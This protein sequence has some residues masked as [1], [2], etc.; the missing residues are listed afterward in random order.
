[1]STLKTTSTLII[2][3]L[4]PIK[5]NPVQGPIALLTFGNV[6]IQLE[7]QIMFSLF[8]MLPDKKEFNRTVELLAAGFKEISREMQ[9]AHTSKIPNEHRDSDNKMLLGM[10]NLLNPE[11]FITGDHLL[12]SKETAAKSFVNNHIKP[13][14]EL[15]KLITQVEKKFINCDKDI[16]ELS[17]LIKEEGLIDILVDE[18]FVTTW[19]YE[20]EPEVAFFEFCKIYW[21]G[22]NRNGVLA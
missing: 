13:D 17:Y 15:E 22:Y 19:A 11:S 6:T 9:F 20:D 5:T 12:L 2:N 14:A 16:P 10:D 21:M 7:Q 8:S 18:K 4:T 3:P 1:M